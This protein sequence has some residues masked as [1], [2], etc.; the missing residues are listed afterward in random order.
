MYL[1]VY[2]GSVDVPGF[3]WEATEADDEYSA[4][5]P[6]IISESFPA[7]EEAYEKLQ[8]LL[9]EEHFQSKAIDWGQT[10]AKVSKQDI[11]EFL[12]SLYGKDIMDENPKYIVSRQRKLQRAKDKELTLDIEDMQSL[13]NVVKSLQ[14][15]KTY[16][17]IAIEQ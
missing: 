15:D 1:D 5:P 9:E 17:L 12:Q 2:I 6:E 7:P 4:V 11:I 3:S 13:I 14:D 16:A 10:A 8:E